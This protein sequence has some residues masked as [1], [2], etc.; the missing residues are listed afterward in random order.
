MKSWFIHNRKK[1]IM[2]QETMNATVV[3]STASPV[4]IHKLTIKIP[5]P[6]PDSDPAAEPSSA[7]S[8]DIPQSGSGTVRYKRRS[9]KA[10]L[11]SYPSIKLSA[12]PQLVVLADTTKKPST[13]LIETWA[14]LLK[15]SPDDVERWVKDHQ[16]QG[17]NQVDSTAPTIPSG[18]SE[19]ARTSVQPDE[20]ESDEEPLMI[21]IPSPQMQ[22]ENT[23]IDQP[24]QI[25]PKDQ[26]LLAI[27]TRL[28]SATSDSSSPE[29]VS[30]F[31]TLF[32]P[33]GAMMERF[34]QDIETGKLERMGW[35]FNRKLVQS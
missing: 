33:Y 10:R 14:S 22:S 32:E 2:P 5:G 4:D 31:N 13:R 26:L 25:P 34:V 28:S 23:L 6:K 16:A 17:A 15:A 8:I 19:P 30:Q 24:P 29:T 12:V 7:M 1:L 18:P 27:H 9:G 35:S 11:T 20:S 3:N 21:G